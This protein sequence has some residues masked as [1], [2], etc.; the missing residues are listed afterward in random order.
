MWL[1]AG[2]QCKQFQCHSLCISVACF[3]P[4]SALRRQANLDVEMAGT[5]YHWRCGTPGSDNTIVHYVEY[6]AVVN[7]IKKAEPMSAHY[8][9]CREKCDSDRSELKKKFGLG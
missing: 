4:P 2:I 6:V 1:L 8:F 5:V 3:V 9:A 7:Q